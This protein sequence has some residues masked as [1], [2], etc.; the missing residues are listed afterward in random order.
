MKESRRTSA[1]RR[2]RSAPRRP[3]TGRARWIVLAAMV[4][5]VALLTLGVG[6]T[7][8]AINQE[9]HDDFCASCHTQPETRYYEQER[10]ANAATLAAFHSQKST[11]CIDCH[12]GGGPFGR[13]EGLA[14][15]AQD[16]VAF[17]SGRYH[18][19]AISENKLGDDSCTKCH[20]DTTSTGSFD[21]HFHIW[22][23]RW[24]AVDPKAAGC[25]DCHTAHPTAGSETLYMSE[26][27]VEA[28][29]QACH[30]A[31]REEG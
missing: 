4:A 15:G 11:R 2:K 13:L 10:A 14:Q 16:L 23:P 9:N 26:Q 17:Y 18:N 12:S 28:V 29:C 8:Y 3:L 31:L 20:S 19:P 6:S 1:R 21:R 24:Q 22:L 25:V 7:A 27:P 5:A 30:A